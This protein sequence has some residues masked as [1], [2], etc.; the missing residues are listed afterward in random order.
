MR[1]VLIGLALAL[2]AM[3][4]V[5][6]SMNGGNDVARNGSADVRTSS[7]AGVLPDFRLDGNQA[8]RYAD[9]VTRP[10]LNPE[11]KP[12][13]K[14]AVAVATEPPK[15][16][17]RR[18]LYELLG[19]SDFGTARVA[20]VREV[21]TRRTQ[22]VRKGDVLQEMSVQAVE[23]DRMILSFRGERDEVRLATYTASGRVPQP[24]PLPSAPAPSPPPAPPVAQAAA[25]SAAPPAAP[26]PVGAGSPP[27]TNVAGN[28]QPANQPPADDREIQRLEALVAQSP[29][30]WNRS[31]LDSARQLRGGQSSP[32]Q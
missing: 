20:Q 26:A 27:G 32:G 19:V 17:I 6:L 18:G 24:P 31:R 30:N 8:D 5:Q 28:T 4:V 2:A 7:R 11:R 3:L 23:P 16:Q 21:A 15:P 1:A 25:Q 10:L 14:Q 9:V 12:A 13:P 22:S 29:T